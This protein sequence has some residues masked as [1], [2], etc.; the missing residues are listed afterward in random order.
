MLDANSKE[1]LK[2]ELSTIN[3]YIHN[4]NLIRDRGQIEDLYSTIMNYL[5]STY[6][7]E[8]RF[9]KPTHKKGTIGMPKQ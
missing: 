4:V 6:L 5:H 3:R 7:R 8:C 2:D 9:A 1:K